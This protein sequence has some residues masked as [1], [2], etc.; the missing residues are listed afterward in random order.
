MIN[1]D[2]HKELCDKY[3]SVKK[4]AKYWETQAKT[5]RVRNEQLLDDI[6]ILSAQ[7]KL[8]KGTGL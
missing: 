3:E 5:L 4:D 7:L 1:R 6:T 8:W 2:T